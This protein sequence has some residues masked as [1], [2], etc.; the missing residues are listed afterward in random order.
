V[1]NL[2]ALA[3]RKHREAEKAAEHP[4]VAEHHRALSDYHKRMSEFHW[5]AAERQR[6]HG[7][8]EAEKGLTAEP[9]T[10]EARASK[11]AFHATRA[12]FDPDALGATHNAK[13]HR[14]VA[15][16]H[17]AAAQVADMVSGTPHSAAR[18]KLHRAYAKAHRDI[19]AAHEAFQNG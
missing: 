4:W 15:T 6:N 16:I 7:G 5:D 12:A 10:S 3:A 13:Y 14:E 9:E 18:A 1:A 17:D 11:R 8:E 2:H 19:A